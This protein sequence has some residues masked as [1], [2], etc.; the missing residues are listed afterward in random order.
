[1]GA[2]AARNTAAAAIMVRSFFIGNGRKRRV[3]YVGHFL[4]ARA[5]NTFWVQHKKAAVDAAF[6]F[7]SLSAIGSL[8]VKQIA[9]QWRV[10]RGGTLVLSAKLWSLCYSRNLT[11]SSTRLQ[12]EAKCQGSHEE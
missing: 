4:L 10:Q 2:S 1:M 11:S 9:S 12:D 5:L 7:V 6:V 3:A 8:G